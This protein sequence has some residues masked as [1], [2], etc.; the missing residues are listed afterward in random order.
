MNKK[1]Q[2]EIVGF[3]LIVVLVVVGLMVYLAI[4]VGNAPE[5]EESPE[6]ENML[7]A[8]MK[9][10]T[11]CAIVYIPD[12]DDFEDLFKSSYKGDTCSNLGIS[13]L[14]YLNETVRLVLADIMATEATVKAYELQFSKRHSDDSMEGI[15]TFFEGNCA[16]TINWA[17]RVIL[18]GSD[19]LIVKLKTCT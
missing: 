14:E 9:Q 10:T 16:G 11:E 15:L 1:A 17:Q 5:N 12:Y 4:S 13:A 19:S 2:Q 18:M 7:D 3:V 6:V 8:L